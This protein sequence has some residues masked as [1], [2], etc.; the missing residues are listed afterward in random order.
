MHSEYPKGRK[1]DGYLGAK[2]TV[3]CT[4]DATSFQSEPLSS[5]IKIQV[6]SVSWNILRYSSLS[7]FLAQEGWC[8]IKGFMICKEGWHLWGLL[9]SRETD[10]GLFRRMKS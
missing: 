7:I 6:A 8:I 4:D 2:K 3:C 5:K 10:M 9:S 1:K